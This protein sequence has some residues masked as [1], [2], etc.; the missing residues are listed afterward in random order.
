[1]VRLT[2]L[3]KQILASIHLDGECSPE[4]IARLLKVSTRTV[5]YHLSTLNEKGLTSKAPFID[6]YPLGFRYVNIYFSIASSAGG[7]AAR[8]VKAF[9][10]SEYVSWLAELGG[11]FHLG[12]SL[13]VENPE[14]VPAIIE[15]ISAK[16]GSFYFEKSIVLHTTLNVYPSKVLATPKTRIRS[17]G[18]AH[19][20]T[21]TRVDQLDI[22]IL[23]EMS[24]NRS[25]TG[26]AI[27]RALGKPHT[28]IES[29]LKKLRDNGV[30]V[31]YWFPFEI[32]KLGYQTFK[33]LLFARGFN[34]SLSERLNIF[35]EKHQNISYLIRCIGSWDFEIGVDVEDGSR[36]APITQEIFDLFGDQLTTVK[37]VPMFRVLKWNQ[38][39][40]A[41]KLRND[42]RES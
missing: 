2:D 38:L 14:E 29:R 16:L 27:A 36:I 21:K 5:R 17:I 4:S 35:C 6:V 26:R 32:T 41:I 37:V 1:M 15:R 39:P 20:G 7:T 3:Q 10:E 18:Y 9:K 22:D 40:P 28:T 12:T 19:K 11:D 24:N 23:R 33:L 42:K 31:G 8:V 13:C 30:I 34:E 25:C